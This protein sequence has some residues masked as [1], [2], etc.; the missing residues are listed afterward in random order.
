[1]YVEGVSNQSG[2]AMTEPPFLTHHNVT[3]YFTHLI[4]CDAGCTNILPRVINALN[5]YIVHNREHLGLNPECLCSSPLVEQ[6]PGTQKVF[7]QSSGGTGHTDTDPPHQGL[8]D[9]FPALEKV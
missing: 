9:V 8:K 1:M 5:W 6:A 3:H 2:L 7:K 4:L